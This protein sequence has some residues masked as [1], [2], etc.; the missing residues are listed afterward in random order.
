VFD[1]GA[2]AWENGWG[3]SGKHDQVLRPGEMV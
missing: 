2:A 3:A 1:L